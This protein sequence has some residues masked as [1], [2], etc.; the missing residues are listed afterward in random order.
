MSRI[1]LSAKKVVGWTVVSLGVGVGVLGLAILDRSWTSP[2]TASQWFDLFTVAL[3]GSASLFASVIAIRNPRRAGFVFLLCTPF[4]SALVFLTAIDPLRYGMVVWYYWLGNS[5]LAG[6]VLAVPGG[7]WLVTYRRNWLPLRPR[8]ER[9]PRRKM[10]EVVSVSFLLIVLVSAAAI[11][12]AIFTPPSVADCDKRATISR[13]GPGQ[14]VFVAKVVSTLGSCE[15]YGHRRMCGGAVAIVRERFWGIRSKIVLLTQGLFENGEQYLVDGVDL[16][17]PLT[18]FL[19]IIAFRPCNHSARIQ[20]ADVDLRV[21]R[22]RASQSI[23]AVRIIG[24]VIRHQGHKTEGIPGSVVVVEGP[25]GTFTLTTD[26]EGIYDVTGVSPGRY[27][28]H[29]Q[30]RG[31]KPAW[32]SQCGWTGYVLKPGDVGGCELNV[33]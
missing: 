23:A 33:D 11:V 24:R 28:I 31:S 26:A 13:L 10:T 1:V 18:R 16:R 25:A 29:L 17:G 9:D 14:V 12:L 2:E 32:H 8:R 6:L 3:F 5:L 15:E 4:A 20:D 21:L 27:E 30:A 19:P 22:D 7:F